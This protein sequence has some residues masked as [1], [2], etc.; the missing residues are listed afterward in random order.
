[1]AYTKAKLKSSGDKASPYFRS[2]CV[3]K[4]SKKYLPKQTLLYVSFKHILMS[5]NNFMGIA[6]S[7]RIMCNASLLNES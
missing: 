5:L 6:N 7:I 4:L 1:M 2:F 3:E